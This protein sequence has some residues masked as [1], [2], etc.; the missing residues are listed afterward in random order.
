MEMHQIRYFLAVA[1]ELNFTRAAQK[2]NVAQPSLTRAIKLL[3][4]EFGGPLFHRERANT[5]LSELGRMIMPCLEDVWSRTKDARRVADGFRKLQRTELRLGVMCTIAPNQLVQ[6]F[7]EI[8]TRHQ[9]IDL[10]II[11]ATAVE[12]QERLLSGDLEVAIY[13]TGEKQPDERLHE[14]PLFHEQM[15]IVISPEH[16]LAKQN[17]IR[18]KDLHGE[19]YLERTKC[20]FGMVAAAS[21]REQGVVDETI[22]SCER[23]DWILAMVAA[24]M[25]YAFM[26]ASNV[27]HNDVVARPMIEPEFWRH[28]NLVTV[29][30]RPHSPAVGALVR[31]VM[32]ANWLGQK[33][34][35]AQQ[36]EKLQDTSDRPGP[37]VS[38]SLPD[39]N[40]KVSLDA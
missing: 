30:G 19:L 17:A 36:A 21:F 2:C 18:L 26:P 23:D 40:A 35:A 11:D 9:G 8:Q 1:E 25:G 15:M 10:K 37:T 33:A 31:E 20:E 22:C 24:G 39:T 28:I 4:D 13:C 7:V 32:R 38:G 3:E 6:L 16:R 14:M 29:R 34:I 5:H 12:L 27:V